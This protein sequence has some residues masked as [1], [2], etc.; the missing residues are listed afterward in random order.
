[1]KYALTPIALVCFTFLTFSQSDNGI[2]KSLEQIKN[3]SF[4]GIMMNESLVARYVTEYQNNALRYE[5]NLA[6]NFKQIQWILIEPET[7]KPS[8]FTGLE[9]GKIDKDIV[10]I[11][12]G[13]KVL[14]VEEI[15]RP[16]LD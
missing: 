4:E 16:K 8:E 13:E 11:G 7:N 5:I 1:M 14:A 15:D 10:K 3:N 9:L 2:G 6:E 12:G